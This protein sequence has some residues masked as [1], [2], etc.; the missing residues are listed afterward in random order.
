MV[1]PTRDPEL[2]RSTYD[3]VSIHPYG[4]APDLSDLRDQIA[5]F[6]SALGAIDPGVP[7]WCTEYGWNG[8]TRA[9]LSVGALSRFA[10]PALDVGRAYVGTIAGIVAV[11]LK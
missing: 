8:A 6:A 5:E 11:N 3:A 10:T 2:V 4:M 9:A 7:L 1:G